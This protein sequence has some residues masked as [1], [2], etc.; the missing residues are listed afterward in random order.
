[1]SGNLRLDFQDSPDNVTS[2]NEETINLIKNQAS[3]KRV[4]LVE[5]A[6]RDS[7][8]AARLAFNSGK[9][10][11]FVP[12]IVQ[13]G[14]EFGK[15]ET[16]LH[17]AQHLR[18]LAFGKFSVRSCEVIILS[19]PQWWHAAAGRFLEYHVLKYGFSP[20]CIACHMYLHACRVPL[21]LKLKADRIISGE[22]LSHDTRFKINQ[23]EEAVSA[24]KKVLEEMGVTL[25]TPLYE[26]SS[27]KRIADILGEE[28]REAERQMRCVLEKNYISPKREILPDPETIR[29]YCEE[30]LIP[31][32][33][34]VLRK[35]C[36]ENTRPDYLKIS[37][38]FTRG[39]V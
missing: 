8:A 25:E 36:F 3:G 17:N 39:E 2:F 18:E 5:V 23:S 6:G 21:A 11:F 28:W 33:L 4:A 13:T 31:F 20:V 16:V 7:Y 22:R 14:T 19:S 30:F 12:T 15:L 9:F 10:D 26:I 1:M 24:Y 35:I 37:E 29:A 34:R 32:T 27:G 38:E